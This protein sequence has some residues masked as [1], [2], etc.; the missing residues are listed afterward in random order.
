MSGT[1]RIV[2]VVGAVLL[3]ILIILT[4]YSI[5]G[6]FEHSLSNPPT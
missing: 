1:L 2:S 3:A 4:I 5:T 6:G